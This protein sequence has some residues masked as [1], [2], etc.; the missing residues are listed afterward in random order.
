MEPPGPGFWRASWRISA[1]LLGVLASVATGGAAGPRF[2]DPAADVAAV[3]DVLDRRLALM[4]EVAAWKWRQHQ[5]ITDAERERQVVAQSVTGAQA[6]N[7]E[8]EAARAFFEVQIRMARAMQ[9]HLFELWQNT[10]ATPPP[11]RELGTELRPLLDAIGRELLPKVYRATAALTDTPHAELIKQLTPL[12][13]HAGVD[14]EQLTELARSLAGLRLTAAPTWATMQR[15][16][17]VRV[18][19]TGDY[20]PFSSDRGGELRGFDVRLAQTLA[21]AWGVQVVFVRTTWPTLMQDLAGYRFDLALSGISVT[22]ERAAHAEFSV[23]Y[24]V[25]GKTPIARR[26]NAARFATLE[27]IDQPGVRVIVNPGG[28]NERFVRERI[29][30]ATVVVHADNRT[31]FDEI[32]TGRADVMFTDA[33]EV[34]LQSRQHPEL[35]GTMATPL[36]MAPKAVLLPPHSELKD[37][38]DAWLTPLAASGELRGQLDAA[39]EEWI[40]LG[41]RSN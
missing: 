14:D 7:L 41:A 9:A 21:H 23:A 40:Q 36:T 39:L 28:T 3:V 27:Q 18:G 11:G 29:S 32:V 13:R 34:R 6:L 2:A 10:G 33:I 1:W 17:V 31:V 37:R 5:A 38:I 22:P 8:G 16:G 20:A 26:E 12:R 25:D 35:G 19:M 15:V 30:R 24:H 4:P